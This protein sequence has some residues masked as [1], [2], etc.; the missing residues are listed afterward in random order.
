MKQLTH[1]MLPKLTSHLYD[2]EAISSI[3]LTK[4]IA[5]KI[6]EVID[7]LNAMEKERLT[8]FLDHEGEI[9]KGILYMKDNLANTIHDL[10]EVM[11]YNGDLDAII[12]DFVMDLIGKAEDAISRVEDTVSVKSFGA[13]GN[14]SVDDTKAIQKAIDFAFENN[15]EVFIPSGTY[16]ISDSLKLYEHQ[17]L[18]G[19]GRHQT[20]IHKEGNSP[21]I[22]FV[23]SK[24]YVFDYTEGQKVLNLAIKKL[25]GVES[26]GIYS[27]LSCPYALI[28][29]VNIDEFE[30]GIHFA[31]GCWV[32]TISNVNIFKCRTGIKINASGTSTH[33]EN[34]YVMEA[35]VIGY[36]IEGLSYSNWTNVCADWC[37]G[38]VY[39]FNFC[40][41]NINGLGCE[42]IE[43]VTGIELNN[44][45]IN[46][47][48]ANIFALVNETS[49][50]IVGNGSQLVLESSSIGANAESKGK[51][52][53][54]VTKF[55]LQLRNCKLNGIEATATSGYAFNTTTFDTGRSHYH[56][57][58]DDKFSYIGKAT[59]DPNDPH[60]VG[61]DIPMPT[62]FGNVMGDVLIGENIDSRQWKQVKRAGDIFINQ[63][64]G[65]H[66]AFYQQI[67]DTEKYYSKGLVTG[68]SGNVITVSSVSLGT[69][70]NKRGTSI[71]VGGTLY[72]EA[73]DETSITGV[74]LDS[75]TI[76]VEDSSLFNLN[77]HFYYKPEVTFMYEA[78]YRAVQH[79][80]VGTKDER[81]NDAP[82][83]FM[84]F[85]MNVM[86]PI[87]KTSTRWVD[88]NGNEV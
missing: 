71:K 88:A 22:T 1:Y 4:E 86:K 30:I 59:N 18:K 21:A 15:K 9:Q 40:S 10:L 25:D 61:Y 36:D 78:T 52:C 7:V 84:Y 69:A 81:P 31:K 62:I 19:T 47:N 29:N 17:T 55:D 68:I 53:N 51:F 39:K 24:D 66:I 63:A 60:K 23:R 83:G 28:D 77:E 57:T 64:P 11:K 48:S 49:T 65:N 42:C 2:K 20:F 12:K 8:R 45:R 44:S 75:C 37:T 35:D 85:D 58:L 33:L 67:T 56:T 87:W 6:N 82:L 72:N 54:S 16:V 41:I 76:T 32:A 38:T 26:V 13:V 3:A 5:N 34:T 70:A 74:N 27:E 14:G 43:A 80:T 46:I 73:G 79:I 50:Y